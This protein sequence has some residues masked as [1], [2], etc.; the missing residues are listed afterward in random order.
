MDS[1]VGRENQKITTDNTENTERT[2]PKPENDL[3]I[4]VDFTLSSFVFSSFHFLSVL[5]VLCVVTNRIFYL[6]RARISWAGR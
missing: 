1:T 2:K 6:A 4:P 5:S 3:K